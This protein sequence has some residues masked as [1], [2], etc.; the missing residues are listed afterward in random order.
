MLTMGVEE[1]FLLLDQDGAV[2]PVAEEAVRRGGADD[3]ELQ[4][5]F[6]SYQLETA[7]PVCRSLD[8]LHAHLSRLRR[9]AAR[10]ADQAGARLVSV[11]VPPFHSGGY[12]QVSAQPR[13]LELARRYPFGPR[14]GAACACQVHVGVP[15]PDLRVQVLAGL[16]PWLPTLLALTANSVISHGADTGW[17]S[18]RYRSLLKWPSFRPPRQWR[19]Q[20]GYDRAV[21]RLID[22]GAAMDPGSVYLLARLSARY[23]TVEVRV[24]DACLTV[25]DTVLLAALVRGLVTTIVEEQHQ[26]PEPQ[27]KP[28]PKL[29]EPGATVQSGLLH[30]AHYGLDAG[31]K[32]VALDRLFA[33]ISPT[34]STDERRDVERRLDVVRREGNGADRQRELWASTGRPSEFVEALADQ[35]LPADIAA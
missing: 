7:T 4:P 31:G 16:R 12:D 28:K 24:A 1:E 15:D 3:G 19:G 25:D 8:E 14:M 11:G 22:R 32:Q 27:P 5:E 17:S 20:R 2:A 30:A 13:Y 6:M 35:A 18:D 10:G 33:H 21:Q 23:P 26:R 9:L 29:D 34:L